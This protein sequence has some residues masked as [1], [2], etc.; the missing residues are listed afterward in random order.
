MSLGE[1]GFSIWAQLS[2]VPFLPNI[3]FLILHF[4]INS[5]YQNGDFDKIFCHTFLVVLGKKFWVEHIVY[6]YSWWNSLFILKDTQYIKYHSITH[7]HTHTHTHT[8]FFFFF[9]GFPGGTS[10]KEPACQCKRH[11]RW[12]I[13]DPWVGKIF[14]RRMWKPTLAWRIPWI[15]EPDGLQFIG[16]QRVRHDWN[17]LACTHDLFFIFWY[18]FKFSTFWEVYSGSF[19]NWQILLLSLIGY[20]IIPLHFYCHKLFDFHT[21]YLVLY[22]MKQ[23]L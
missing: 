20:D 13:R 19:S 10:G 15:E 11:K 5:F 6:H 7:T 9:Q 16:L 18:S 12:D 17:D 8:I 2:G 14:W 22:Q 23:F 4:L 21:F 3:S 1:C